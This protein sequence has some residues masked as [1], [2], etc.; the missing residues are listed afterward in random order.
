MA[1]FTKL[2]FDRLTGNIARAVNQPTGRLVTG[3]ITRGDV[4]E[5]NLNIASTGSASVKPRRTGAILIGA[6]FTGNGEYRWEINS[7]VLTVTAN[8]DLTGTFTF[9]VF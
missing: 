4:V 3:D 8:A 1:D 2:G 5:V 7:T 9:W 6:S